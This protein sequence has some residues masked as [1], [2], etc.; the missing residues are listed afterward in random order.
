MLYCTAYAMWFRSYSNWL[1]RV[2]SEC[3]TPLLNLIDMW[4]KGLIISQCRGSKSWALFNH[5]LQ[6]T[7]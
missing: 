2:V 4:Q 7:S 5:V 3:T 6:A 1:E